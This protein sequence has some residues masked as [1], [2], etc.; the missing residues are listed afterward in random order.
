MVRI[1]IWVQQRAKLI[2]GESIWRVFVYTLS[3]NTTS[4]KRITFWD[5][6]RK[7][8]RNYTKKFNMPVLY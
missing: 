8:G 2:R 4:V 6:Y 5:M 7:Q 1:Y 3:E